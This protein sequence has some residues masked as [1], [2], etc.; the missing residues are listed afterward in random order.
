MSRVREGEKRHGRD[1]TNSLAKE[2]LGKT[3]KGSSFLIKYL[4]GMVWE[5]G[6]D[7]TIGG[8]QEGIM[9]AVHK[10][11]KSSLNVCTSRCSGNR[12]RK[13]T[14]IRTAL[15]SRLRRVNMEDD[16]LSSSLL[17]L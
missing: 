9:W 15:R 2:V 4:P 8:I 5:R 1:I 6:I 16:R 10:A 11:E 12:D 14:R 7:T 17:L 3:P 13:E